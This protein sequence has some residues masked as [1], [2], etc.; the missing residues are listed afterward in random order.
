MRDITACQ[1]KY[2]GQPSWLLSIYTVFI[3]HLSSTIYKWNEDWLR[4][5]FFPSSCSLAYR[6]QR[7]IKRI[8]VSEPGLLLCAW[9]IWPSVGHT[10]CPSKTPHW[11]HQCWMIRAWSTCKQA[12]CHEADG[13][14]HRQSRDN[15]AVRNMFTEDGFPS[16]EL[17]DIC[18]HWPNAIVPMVKALCY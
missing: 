4:F 16:W 12:K 7:S 5:R 6:L 1:R 11:L 3:Y 8:T 14:E 10:A 18:L 13:N 17:R 15:I 9:N 2:V